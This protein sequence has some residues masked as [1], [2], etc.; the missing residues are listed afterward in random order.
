MHPTEY[1]HTDQWPYHISAGGLVHRIKDDGTI[2]VVVLYRNL[3]E[4]R[5]YH[6]PKGTLHYNE[7]LETDAKRE[8]L[9]ESGIEAKIEGYLGAFTDDFMKDGV[10]IVKTTHYFA[11]KPLRD[12][13]HHDSEH[14]GVEWM[15]ISKA[16]KLLEE[17]EPKKKEYLILDRLA[18]FT[19]LMQK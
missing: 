10:H 16:R 3:P 1:R 14:D 2:E 7:T 5:H 19:K 6:L 11:M 4:G 13:H 18:D 9:E 12:T 17:T 15:E 8:V